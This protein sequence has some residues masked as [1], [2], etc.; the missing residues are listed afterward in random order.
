MSKEEDEGSETETGV[1]RVREAL[2]LDKMSL[3]RIRVS[4]TEEGSKFVY[5]WR[6]SVKQ[7]RK[8]AGFSSGP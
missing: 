5:F 1:R 7:E 2:N 3:L 8:R 6:A 4:Y